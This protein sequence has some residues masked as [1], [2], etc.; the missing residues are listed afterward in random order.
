MAETLFARIG[1]ASIAFDVTGQ[2][3]PVVLLHAG[4]GDRRMWDD[5]VPTFAEHFTVIR[6]DA[7]G[8]GDTRRPPSEY[9]AW[10]DVIALLEYLGHERAH[11]V[12]V[13]MGSQTAF[14]T[15]VAAPDR[16]SAL[17]AVS[18][19]TGV[20]ASDSLRAG[21]KAVDELVEAGDIDE[22]N[23][24]EL[25]MW[26]DGPSREPHAVPAAMRER[27]RA[28]NLDLLTRDDTE[29]NEQEPASPTEEGLSGISCP[30]L[31]VWGDQDVPDVQVAG[32]RLVAAIPGARQL[33]IPGTAHL[34]NLEKPAEFNRIV[35][36]FLRE[37]AASST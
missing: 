16:V 18:A 37:A 1:D 22:A 34:P 10:Q 21:W 23:E 29:D 15:A 35:L 4:L 20:P 6:F 36:D 25:R 28:M 19:R 24:Y 33:I 26:V 27:V 7:R 32:P 12:G 9:W 2:G 13:S 11:L 14:D 5:Q 30:T 17:V 31:I 3:H 8:F